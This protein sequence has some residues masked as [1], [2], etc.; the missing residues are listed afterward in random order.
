MLRLAGVV[1]VTV[2]VAA[3]GTSAQERRLGDVA[4]DIK[5]EKNKIEQSDL[6]GGGRRV[7]VSGGEQLHTLVTSLAED[8]RQFRALLAQAAATYDV[9]YGEEWR[10]EVLE[11]ADALET[12]ATRLRIQR[13]PTGLERAHWLASYGAEDVISAV[14]GVRGLLEADSFTYQGI[15]DIIDQGLGR[16]DEAL[17]ILGEF[18]REEETESSL[19]EGFDSYGAEQTI[20]KRCAKLWASDSPGYAECIEEQ[21]AAFAALRGRFSFSVGLNE[22]TFAKVR[23]SCA[24]D[25]PDDFVDRNH[26]EIRRGEQY[27]RKQE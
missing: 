23:G 17:R 14:A 3:G 15:F 5:L 21:E 7:H 11:R 1:V 9:F 24:N 8:L 22:E 19:T 13:P 25:H 6:N 20:K 18:E 27:R 16:F 12:N 2:C 26:C 4:K 10:A